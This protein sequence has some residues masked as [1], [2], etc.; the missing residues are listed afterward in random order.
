MFWLVFVHHFLGNV[1]SGPL[2]IFKF[3]HVLSVLCTP[4]I[5]PLSDRGPSGAPAIL[6]VSSHLLDG[7]L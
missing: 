2:A 5:S 7:V 1:Y 4:D 3:G 6:G